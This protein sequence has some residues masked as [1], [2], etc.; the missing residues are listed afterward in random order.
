MMR[1]CGICAAVS[2]RRLASAVT[3]FMA[4]SIDIAL[5]VADFMALP[6]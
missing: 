2:C 1:G 6:N 4:R 3:F 5:D